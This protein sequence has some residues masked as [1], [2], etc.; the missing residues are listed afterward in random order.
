[1]SPVGHVTYFPGRGSRSALFW[2]LVAFGGRKGYAGCPLP[3]DAPEGGFCADATV[4]FAA[5]TFQA[6]MFAPVCRPHK[7]ERRHRL[8][9]RRRLSEDR[10]GSLFGDLVS[11]LSFVPPPGAETGFQNAG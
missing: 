4:A 11:R 6:E 5:G 2:H 3:D 1:M 8:G 7:Q 9:P 10:V